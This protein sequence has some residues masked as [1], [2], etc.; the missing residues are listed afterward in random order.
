MYLGMVLGIAATNVAANSI[1]LNSARVYTA[2]LLLIPMGL[3]GARLLF[4]ALHWEVFKG[5]LSRI[6]SRQDGGSAVYGGILLVIVASVPVTALLHLH[7][8]AFW[9]VAVFTFLLG[10]MFT[11][12]GC[13][14]NGCC[15]GRPTQSRLALLLPDELGVWERRF[16]A[17]LF[18]SAWAAALLVVAAF[19]LPRRPFSGAVFLLTL[20]FYSLGRVVLEN[21]RTPEVDP[22]QSVQ[23]AHRAVQLL[24]TVA[25][26]IL[27]VALWTGK[28]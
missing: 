12:V 15:T 8:G 14:L 6:W 7:L 16:P 27:V 21:V 4:V 22:V 28:T 3:I 11:R 20:G 5:R 10:A 25:P 1:G 2:T 17:Q 13:L 9:D 23:K 18:A 24:L 19:L 26:I